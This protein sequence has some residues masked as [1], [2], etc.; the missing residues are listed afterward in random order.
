MD[1]Q[2]I[3]AKALVCEACW[4]GLFSFDAWQ[5]VLAAT[6]QPGRRGYSKGYCYVTAWE[7][8]HA[9]AS[10]GC[11]W[12]RFLARPKCTK[13]ELEVWVAYDQASECT[14][15]G[16]KKLTVKTEGNGPGAS[17]FQ[18][19]SYYM[20]TDGGTWVPFLRCQHFDVDR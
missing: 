10:A 3:A 17:S 15:A 12:C 1:V 2:G 6:Q 8:I 13:G 20:Y 9:S 14:P 4:N 5:T 11:N 19:S 7:A 18:L 16:T